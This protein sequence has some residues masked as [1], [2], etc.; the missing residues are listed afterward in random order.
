[1]QPGDLIPTWPHRDDKQDEGDNCDLRERVR[2]EDRILPVR[3]IGCRNREIEKKRSDRDFANRR[4]AKIQRRHDCD[5]FSL[6][7]IV[8]TGGDVRML[9]LSARFDGTPTS[10]A[11]AC[12]LSKSWNG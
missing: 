2:P 5:A 1:M 7:A 8:P 4:A 12:V 11:Q 3:N 6:G 10:A 9:L